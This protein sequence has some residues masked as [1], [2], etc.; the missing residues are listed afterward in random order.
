MHACHVHVALDGRK[1]SPQPFICGGVRK[2]TSEHL[3]ECEM[4]DEI[5]GVGERG[6]P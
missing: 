2:V 5:A 1:E 4:R 6:G 3:G